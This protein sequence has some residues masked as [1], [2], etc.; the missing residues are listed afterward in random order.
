M[1]FSLS[2]RL[3]LH[4]F[5]RLMNQIQ[6][7]CLYPQVKSL[8]NDVHFWDLIVLNAELAENIPEY[9]G[10]NGKIRS[11]NPNAVIVAYFSGQDV[12]PGISQPLTNRYRKGLAPEWYLRDKNGKILPLYRLK[13]GEWTDAL[14]VTTALN[15][16]LPKFLN[17]NV[18]RTEALDGVFYDWASTSISS[19][20]HRKLPGLDHIDIDNDGK[21]DPDKELDRLWIQGWLTML[22][23]SRSIFPQ[24][25]L[26]IGNGGWSTGDEYAPELNGI[27]VEQFLK[28]KKRDAERYGWGAQ[29]R[30]Y[31]FYQNHSFPPRISII[32][33]N[34]NNQRNFAR[35][36]FALAST[37]LFDGYF[38][39]TND[40][41]A[42]R[43]C[44]WYDEYSVDLHSGAA[45]HKLQ[46][47]GYLGAPLGSAFNVADPGETLE[48][49][50]MEDKKKAENQVWR[51]DFENGI[52]LV[53]PDN[54]PH[55]IVLGSSYRKIRGNV[56]PDFN[57][58]N[59][60]DKILLSPESGVVLL[61]QEAM[62]QARF[63][64]AE[65]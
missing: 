18:F 14:N 38:C 56:D 13:S 40:T 51:R 22:R 27:M 47:K 6:S 20:N 26:I 12:Y 45:V 29:M 57:D 62:K 44:R 23:N 10:P 42:Y 39:F 36:R 5:P 2:E 19:M 1:P 49:V 63:S 21:A 55:N 41:G 24:N 59:T 3:S 61:K 37:L 25:A 32:M 8:L 4:G 60:V 30:S 16:Y 54:E 11:R 52:V 15:E 50:L 28:M 34:D 58:G 35:V 17:K 43:N 48:S 31:A 65:N 53:N 7:C 64:K 33:S 9:V 46:N